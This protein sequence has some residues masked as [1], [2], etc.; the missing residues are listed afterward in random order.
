M[1]QVKLKDATT[2]LADLV[3]AAL[4]GE[5]VLITG[6]NQA[7]VRLVPVSSPR[8]RRQSG[9]ARGLVMLSADFDAPLDDFQE[10][11]ALPSSRPF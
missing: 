7:A 11:L 3:D 10:Y 2:N 1:F 6:E 8:Q 4:R 9:S 5:M